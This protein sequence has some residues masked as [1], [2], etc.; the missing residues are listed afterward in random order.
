ML[1]FL[2]TK[3]EHMHAYLPSALSRTTVLPRHVSPNLS[4]TSNAQILQPAHRLIVIAKIGF[5]HITISVL[6]SPSNLFSHAK[7]R[8]VSG[9]PAR[10][11]SHAVM[12]QSW[13]SPNK[14]FAN[15][16]I[17]CTASAQGFGTCCHL[18]WQ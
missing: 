15:T 8:A 2:L 16:L 4:T 13:S 1:H 9:C 11:A 10:S 17:M 7:P 18:E 14:V 5:S 6:Q 3:H 12:V